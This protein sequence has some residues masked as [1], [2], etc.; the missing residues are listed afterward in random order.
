[1]LSFRFHQY[2]KHTSDVNRLQQY[3]MTKAQECRSGANSQ[4][5]TPDQFS[6]AKLELNKKAKQ[7]QNI[8]SQQRGC[9]EIKYEEA[10]ALRSAEQSSTVHSKCGNRGR[11]TKRFHFLIKINTT[12][13]WF[14]NSSSSQ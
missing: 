11:E 8:A 9:S 13:L 7:V 3:L 4:T 14:P 2:L 6:S 1:M 5:M 12:Q 10:M